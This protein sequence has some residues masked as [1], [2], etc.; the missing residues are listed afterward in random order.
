MLIVEIRPLWESHLEELLA[1]EA[2]CFSSPWSEQAFLGE[3]QQPHSFTFGVFS[4]TDGKLL[5]YIV[6][7]LLDNEIHILNLGVH[8]AIRREGLASKLLLFLIDTAQRAGCRLLF[9]E[10]RPSNQ[11]ALELYRSFGFRQVGV[12][13]NYYLDTKEDALLYTLFLEETP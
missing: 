13:P 4:K 6:F 3:F 7:W 1:I 11:P 8:P 9:L 2:L 10:V 12:R 5:G